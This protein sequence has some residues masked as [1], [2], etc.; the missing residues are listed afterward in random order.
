MMQGGLVPSCLCHMLAESNKVTFDPAYELTTSQEW[1]STSRGL[2]LIPD[3]C[4]VDVSGRLKCR[5]YKCGGDMYI[6]PEWLADGME[7]HDALCGNGGPS[8]CTP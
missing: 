3:W 8:P 7:W 4:A 6:D 5:C 2:V 1:I